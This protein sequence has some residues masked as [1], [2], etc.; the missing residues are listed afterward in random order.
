MSQLHLKE[1][2]TLADYQ[3]YIRDMVRERG[4][5]GKPLSETFMLFMEECG[6]LAKAARKM[7]GQTI[8]KNSVFGTVEEEVADVLIMLVTIAN[9]LDVNVEKAFRDKEERNKKRVWTKAA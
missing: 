5:E 9:E 3:Q 2:P 8:D 6:E 1:N 4:F 7:T